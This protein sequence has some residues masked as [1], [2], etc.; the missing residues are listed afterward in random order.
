MTF[1]WQQDGEQVLL[2]VDGGSYASVLTE[3]TATTANHFGQ[4]VFLSANRPHDALRPVIGPKFHIVD[5]ITGM[6]GIL[7]GNLPDVMFIESPTLLEKAALR[8][9]QIL[10]RMPGRS[11]LIVDSLSTL[12]MYNDPD[13]V[14]ELAHNMITRLRLRGT[15]AAWMMVADQQPGIVDALAPY[16]DRIVPLEPAIT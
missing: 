4:G 8:A 7:P 11:A 1:A 6:T 10:R 2:Q 16:C 9:E 13:A 15:A 3:V 14:V 12:A 5:C